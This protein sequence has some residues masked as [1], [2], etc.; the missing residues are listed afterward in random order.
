VPRDAPFLPDSFSYSEVSSCFL[1]LGF[2]P[3]LF[4]FRKNLSRITGAFNNN[5]VV[6]F[7]LAESPSSG[8]IY[9]E[10][11]EHSVTFDVVLTVHRR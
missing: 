10:V 1:R 4:N 9:A 8:S 2:R 6:F 7:L 5:C 3:K 11:S